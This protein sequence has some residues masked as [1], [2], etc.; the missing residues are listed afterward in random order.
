V[1][2]GLASVP[3]FAPQVK[4]GTLRGLAVTGAKRSPALPDVPT[5]AE[6]AASRHGG[7]HVPGPVPA[8][9]NPQGDR[10]PPAQRNHEGAGAADVRER[11]GAI[12]LELVGN[13]PEEFAA[14]IKAT[15]RNGAR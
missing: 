7:K 9:G 10:C 11:L 14:Q 1:P 6:E 15:W 4:A 13:R 3:S 2:I 5:M 8:G 12:G